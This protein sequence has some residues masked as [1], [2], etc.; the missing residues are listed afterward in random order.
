MGMN[1]II[2]GVFK[3]S[4][5]LALVFLAFF[6]SIFITMSSLIK[7]KELI[8]P[9]WVG[10]TV[11]AAFEESR[12][13]NIHLQP[14]EGSR[15]TEGTPFSITRQFPE[16]GV[17]IKRFGYVKV[18]YTPRPEKVL[19]PDVCGKSLDEAIKLLSEH[20]IKKGGV[21][22][23]DRDTFPVDQVIGQGIRSGE[24]LD[25]GEEVD[26]L[27]SRGERPY[28]YIMPDFIGLSLTR[29]DGFLK[30]HGLKIAN[31]ESIQYPGLES[32]VIVKQY[33][34]SGFRINAKNLI[35][36]GVSQ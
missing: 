34:L 7:G 2:K 19:M 21:S 35:T 36:L 6:L 22:Y 12:L 8:T 29:V 10:K 33:P 26:M 23:M 32:G 9:N 14:I 4:S 1:Q 24:P 18:Y 17:R 30:N 28:S 15:L 16:P 5:V 13:F 31:I 25:V 27:I 20:G 3:W 11:Q